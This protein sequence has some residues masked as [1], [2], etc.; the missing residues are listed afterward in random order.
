MYKE[1]FGLQ[2][3]PFNLTPDPD[4]LFMTAQHREAMAGITYAVLARKGFVVLTGDA[5]AG[6][7]T[8]LTQILRRLPA[9]RIQSS[10]IVNPTLTPAEFIEAALMDFGFREIPSSKPQ[11]LA[12]LQNFLW[13]GQGEGKTSA[14]V[15][16]EA[17]KLSPEVLEEIRLLGN[18]ESANEK[19]LQI[20]LVGQSELDDL[21]DRE[22]L[23]QL[24]QRIALRLAIEAL[25][26]AEVEQYI[27]H[28]W[29][30]AGGKESPFTNDAVATISEASHGIP[31]AINVICDN[32]LMEAFGEHSLR[33]ETRHVQTVCRALHL[34][35]SMRQSFVKETACGLPVE[36]VGIEQ[37]ALDCSMKSLERYSTPAGQRSVL[38]RL[39]GK[40]RFRQRM[41]TA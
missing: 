3:D 35:M 16:D 37:E 26:P 39:A 22:H 10:V 9:A 28:R 32:A 20:V 18:F 31:R 19:L 7:T 27:Q 24:K 30:K 15:V 2:K 11:R 12:A 6:K 38:A 23:R 29:N 8:L 36:T 21:L 5:G 40:L 14:L 4:F 34:P 17:H 13:T 1:F 25:P 33:L 41:E